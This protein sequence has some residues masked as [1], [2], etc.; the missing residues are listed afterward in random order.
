MGDFGV[1]NAP[2]HHAYRCSVR[3]WLWKPDDRQGVSSHSGSRVDYDERAIEYARANY[4]GDNLHY[5]VGD[6]T[7]WRSEGQPM[8]RC[9]VIVSFDTIEH[10]LHREIALMRI[11]DN[12]ADD[13]WLLFSTPCGHNESRLNPGWEHHKLEY[14]H[15]DLFAILSRFLAAWFSRK[16]TTFRRLSFGAMRSMQGQFDT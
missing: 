14:S 6:M 8:P 9:D 10:L 12:L 5:V 2:D 16:R 13:G 4:H 15:S 11:A 1:T 7:T 3:C